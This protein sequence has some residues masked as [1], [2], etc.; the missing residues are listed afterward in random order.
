MFENPQK[1]FFSKMLPK[2]Q[3]S[4][5]FSHWSAFASDFSKIPEIQMRS[6]AKLCRNILILVFFSKIR[7]SLDQIMFFAIERISLISPQTM[8]ISTKI[9]KFVSSYI[10]VTCAYTVLSVHSTHKKRRKWIYTNGWCDV[11][12]FQKGNMY[13]YRK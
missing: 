6:I 1:H 7:N 12:L 8:Q 3:I 4:R 10:P 9:I 11:V 13:I 2:I 5:Q